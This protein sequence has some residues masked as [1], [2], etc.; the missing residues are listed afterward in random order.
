MTLY[1]YLDRPMDSIGAQAAPIVR[2]MRMWVAGARG[3]RCP[4]G[5]TARALGLR[6]R[7]DGLRHF[8]MVMMTL[9]HESLRALVFG[10]HGSVVTDDEAAILSLYDAAVRGDG[11]GLR[12]M[13]ASVVEPAGVGTVCAA[14]SL[15]AA[16]L[17]LHHIQDIR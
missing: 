15:L 13:A 12:R 2:A 16:S 9:D 14:L 7:D 1:R 5:Q 11:V 6:P 4:C 8:N 10:M 17:S 3:R